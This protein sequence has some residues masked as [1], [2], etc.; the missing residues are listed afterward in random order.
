MKN[1]ILSVLCMF[2]FSTFSVKALMAND[3]E[4]KKARE[5]HK[6]VD[7]KCHVTLV[8]GS[9]AVI[10]WRT[11]PKKLSKLV[12][13]VVGQKVATHKSLEKIKIYKAFQCVLDGDDFTSF[14]ARSIDEKTPR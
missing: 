7:A 2:L 13:S 1:F 9:E 6:K 10:M 12:N 5:E 8:D 14:Q 3:E 11:Q 4:S